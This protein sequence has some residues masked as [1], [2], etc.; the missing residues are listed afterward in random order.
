V[1]AKRRLRWILELANRIGIAEKVQQS[2]LAQNTLWLIT[3][4]GLR[5]V[6]QAVYFALIARSLGTTNYGAFVSAAALVGIASPFASLGAG[7]LLIRD[8]ARDR[9]AFGESWGRAISLT[10]GFGGFLVALITMFAYFVLSGSMS[11]LLV[12]LVAVADV[13]G[14]NLIVVSS[15]SFQAV[16]QLKWTSGI[17]FGMS[18]TRLLAALLLVLRFRH[19]LVLQWAYA[20]L[21]STILVAAVSVFVV[22][23]RL[24]IPQFSVR[25]AIR[26]LREGFFFASGMSAQTVYN[27]LDKTMLARM[28]SLEATGIYGAAYRVIEVSFT[29]VLSL[30]SAAY[31][32]FFNVGLRGI[33]ASLAFARR[34]MLRAF[35]FSCALCLAVI[36]CA[37]LLPLVLGK[38]YAEAAVALRWL[39]LILPLRSIHAFYSDILTSVGQQGLRTLL[40]IGVALVNAGANLWLIPAFSWKGAAWSSV[41]C[42]GLLAV[43][44]GSAVH[45]LSKRGSVRGEV[46]ASTN[47]VE[48]LI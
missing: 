19:P 4:Q 11:P 1:L 2:T 14:L 46:A 10:F 45:I 25:N 29:P 41:G 36:A 43:A 16:E 31:P 17:L 37:G 35:L 23:R 28:G 34:L 12:F 44:V 40:Q 30:L 47:R 3:G 21:G 33:E 18:L 27:D 39:A 13:I 38:Q 24:G 48:E 26:D 42:D 32:R 15:C 5:L 22:T 9:S 7:N 20:Y 6:T 8:V